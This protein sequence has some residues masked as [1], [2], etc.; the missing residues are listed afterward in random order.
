MEPLRTPRNHKKPC[1]TLRNPRTLMNPL[2]F[3]RLDSLKRLEVSII[4]DLIAINAW[5]LLDMSGEI[6]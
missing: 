5:V 6:Y 4:Q 1:G 2:V 3:V